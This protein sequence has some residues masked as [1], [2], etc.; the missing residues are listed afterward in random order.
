MEISP[1]NLWLFLPRR[2]PDLWLCF[3][4]ILLLILRCR[5]RGDGVLTVRDRGPAAVT[6]GTI[7]SHST[8]SHPTTP[9]PGPL[10]TWSTT[11]QTP[12]TRHWRA[13]EREGHLEGTEEEGKRHQEVA[14]SLSP[15]LFHPDSSSHQLPRHYLRCTQVGHCGLKLW[16]Q[17]SQ[18]NYSQIVWMNIT[19]SVFFFCFFSLWGV[20]FVLYYLV[21]VE[22]LGSVTC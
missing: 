13:Q 18:W 21:C 19:C 5:G 17:G 10:H 20:G 7:P 12:Q 11:T 3:S 9:R 2:K 14:A 8:A 4:D 1:L 15:T 16:H 22:T 6:L